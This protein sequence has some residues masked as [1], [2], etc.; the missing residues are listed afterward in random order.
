MQIDGKAAA[1][2]I[3][4]LLLGIAL[5]GV[6][7]GAL[8]R[9]RADEVQALRRPPGFVAHMLET[10]RP[11]SPAQR[12]SLR[13]ILE[14]TA[15]RN[16]TIIRA[17]NDALR[18][19]LDTLRARLAPL[20]DSGQRAR[21]AEEGRLPEPF[22]PGPRDQRPPD[23]GGPPPDRAGPPPRRGGPPPPEGPPP[24]GGDGG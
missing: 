1:I 23:R 16:D 3:G 9:R 19:E 18:T 14:R 11:N 12:D 20:L 4:T 7:A 21:L 2:L 5:G 13:P 15:A 10:I 6:G 22:R 24:R 8:A 17:A